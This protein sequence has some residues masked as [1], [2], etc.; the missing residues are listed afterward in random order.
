MMTLRVIEG[1]PAVRAP[2]PDMASE[3]RAPTL[4]DITRE[5]ERRIAATG[6]DKWRNREALTGMPVPRE[7][8]YLAMQ[9]GYVAEVLGRLAVIPED[10]RSDIYW[11]A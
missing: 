7:T 1:G 3:N 2:L 10:F 4:E 8:R 11:P 6:M 9:I 5:A